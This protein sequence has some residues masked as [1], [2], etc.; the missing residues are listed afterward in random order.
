LLIEA[1]GDFEFTGKDRAPQIKDVAA[2]LAAR[3][4]NG[5]K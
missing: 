2:M 5:T 3:D 1:A 4:L